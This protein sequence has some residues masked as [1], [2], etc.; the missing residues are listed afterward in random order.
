MKNSF[1]LFLLFGV[2]FLGLLGCRAT[3]TLPTVSPEEAATSVAILSAPLPGDFSAI[4][5]LRV[6]KAGGL[7]LSILARP[8]SGRLTISRS[9]GSAL[10]IVGWEPNQHPM[11][12][13][14]REGCSVQGASISDLL[15]VGAL[16]LPQVVRL[17]G[18]RLPATPMDRVTVAPNGKLMVEGDDWTCLVSVA[19]SPWR[20]LRVESV[21]E[22]DDS[23]WRVELNDHDAAMPQHLRFQGSSDRW[24]EIELRRQQW[25]AIEKLP[26]M[27]EL[28]PCGQ[29]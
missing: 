21:G 18:G 2:M 11:L 9:F 10:S 28:E 23:G 22:T 5:G 20:V 15:G 4:Y 24:A 29:S 25:D 6:P 26:D 12:I 27:P 7:R 19:P 3:S 1:V 14:Y 13:D 16:P 17:L 8:E